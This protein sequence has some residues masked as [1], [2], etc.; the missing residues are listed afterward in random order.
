MLAI[1]LQTYRI[2]TLQ[3]ALHGGLTAN[4]ERIPL[5]FLRYWHNSPSRLAV[6]VSRAQTILQRQLW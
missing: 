4:C 3:F 5:P 2:T 6:T 1:R